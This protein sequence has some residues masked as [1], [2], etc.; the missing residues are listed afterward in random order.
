MFELRK[1]NLLCPKTKGNHAIH[2]TFSS[3]PV[4]WNAGL[5]LEEALHIVFTLTQMC[6][7]SKGA[8]PVF[9][10][11][12]SDVSPPKSESTSGGTSLGSQWPRLCAP[13]AGG[14][15]A[16]PDQGNRTSHAAQPKRGKE[17]KCIKI[18]GHRRKVKIKIK[19]ERQHATENICLTSLSFII[20]SLPWIWV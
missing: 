7:S 16:S 1:L 18:V 5:D 11:L 17:R 12:P 20:T 15:E 19:I 2:F 8:F 14:R 6:F 9:I 10:A 3:S 13:N 4:L